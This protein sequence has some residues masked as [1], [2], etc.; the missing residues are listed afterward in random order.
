VSELSDRHDRSMAEA[1]EFQRC[2]DLYGNTV[3]IGTVRRGG[4]AVPHFSD[5]L[6]D[7]PPQPNDDVAWQARFEK[8]LSPF[9]PA[10]RRVF[11]LVHDQ[12]LTIAEIARVEGCQRQAI[13][14]RIKSMLQKSVYCRI[15]ADVGRLK[16]RVNQHG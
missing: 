10:E 13:Y 16:K 2:S 4:Q 1:I 7:R 15:S 11:I 9:T 8:M 14:S 6:W 5:A 3:E 12:G